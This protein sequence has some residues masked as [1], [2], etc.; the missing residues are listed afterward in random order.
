MDSVEKF[1]RALTA[2][3]EATLH[4]EAWPVALDVVKDMLACDMFHSFVWDLDEQRPTMAWA[5]ASASDEMHARYN[6]YFGR[7][8]PRREAADKVPVGGVFAC[9]ELFDDRFVARNEFYQDFLIPGGLR[10]ML[11]STLARSPKHQASLALLRANGRP[12]FDRADIAAASRL[13][14]HLQR[15]L[16]MILSNSDARDALIAG[17]VSLDGLDEGVV[18]LNAAG[19]AGHVNAAGRAMLHAASS[20]R[21]VRGRLRPTDGRCASRFDAAWEEVVSTG[22]PQSVYACGPQGATDAHSVSITLSRLPSEGTL[23]AF[24][25]HRYVAL[26]TR[27]ERKAIPGIGQL[28]A[29]FGLTEVEARLAQAVA[30]GHSLGDFAKER[31]VR[32]ST[33][34]TQWLGVLAKTGMR[35]Q[36]DLVGL[37]SRLPGDPALA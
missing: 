35:R 33:V 27:R 23:F 29:L 4:P 32:I 21:I 19:K 22:M 28:V 1:D 18:L 7:I 17:E 36:Q 3:Y 13:A 15:A 30:R 9:Q 5:S 10:Y 20:V 16:Q 25:G 2:I 26:L 31:G 14:P 12:A 24:W 6:A 34:R 37:L 8:D 11:G